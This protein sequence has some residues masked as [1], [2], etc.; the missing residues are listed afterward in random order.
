MKDSSQAFLDFRFYFMNYAYN[1]FMD[2]MKRCPTEQEILEIKENF[3]TLVEGI[4]EA[5]ANKFKRDSHESTK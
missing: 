4:S 2:K 1:D 5:W 3:K